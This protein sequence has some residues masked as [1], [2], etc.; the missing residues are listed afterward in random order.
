MTR[1]AYEH[2]KAR[3]VGWRDDEWVEDDDVDRPTRECCEAALYWLE[4][5]FRLRDDHSLHGVDMTSA[6]EVG[7][8][9]ETR[10]G[11]ESHTVNADGTSRSVAFG[12]DNKVVRTR[13]WEKRP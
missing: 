4:Y 8:H 3:I 2:A 5:Y 1:E 12:L 6:G 10:D 11:P 9:T 7:I 13:E